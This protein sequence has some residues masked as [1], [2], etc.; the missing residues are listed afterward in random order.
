[1]G[2]KGGVTDQVNAMVACG[3]G[4]VVSAWTLRKIVLASTT[5]S[6]HRQDEPNIIA[7]NV[8]R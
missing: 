1:M 7:R 8:Y 2:Y 6:W 3:I 5:Y 4:L